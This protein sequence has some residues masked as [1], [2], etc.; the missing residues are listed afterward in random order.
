[1]KVSRNKFRKGVCPSKSLAY[2]WF[3]DALFDPQLG[4]RSAEF[5]TPI[6]RSGNYFVIGVL[7]EDCKSVRVSPS[8]STGSDQ[9]SSSPLGVKVSTTMN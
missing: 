4:R 5:Q 2:Q 9:A 3:G 8:D 1:M 6:I 7:D